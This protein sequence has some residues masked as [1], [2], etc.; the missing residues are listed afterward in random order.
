VAGTK[1]G[2]GSIAEIEDVSDPRPDARSI[3]LSGGGFG[4]VRGQNLRIDF[5][6]TGG[7]AQI[8]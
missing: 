5:R 4:L 8:G 3:S 7:D 1:L 6:W 2:F